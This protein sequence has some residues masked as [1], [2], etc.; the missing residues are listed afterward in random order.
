MEVRFICM[1]FDLF[2]RGWIDIL[3]VCGTVRLIFM[4]VRFICMGSICFCPIL[5]IFCC[6]DIK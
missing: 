1:R 6:F 5:F 3:Y 2:L 4:E